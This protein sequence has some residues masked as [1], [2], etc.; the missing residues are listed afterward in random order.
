MYF[1]LSDS[2]IPLKPGDVVETANGSRIIID[3]YQG[4]G[5]FALMYIAHRE[6]S[7]R[8]LA[9]K[10]LFPRQLENLLIQRGEDGR[11][12]ICDPAADAEQDHTPLWRELQKYFVREAALTRK[13]GTAYDQTGHRTAQ[14]NPDVLHAEGPFQ[15]LRGNTY[16]A[17]DTYQGEPLRDLIERG[18]LRDES[19]AVL[20]NHFL[21]EILDILTEAAVRLSALHSEGIWH[22]DLSPDNIYLVPSVGRT[23]LAP[24]IIDYGSSYDRNDPKD[25]AD[26][27]YTYNPFS[28][29]EILALAQLQGHGGGYAPDAS[30]DTYAL[31]AILFY[32]VTGE[33]FTAEHRMNRSRWQ[34]QIRREYAAGL[35]AH[36][37]ADSFA[38]AMIA[39]FDQ[40]LAAAQ[41]DRLPTPDALHEAIKNLR[42]QYEKYGNLLPLVPQDELMSYM[43]LEKYPLYQYRS[44]DGS[45][46][47]L[48]LG[49]GVFV[50]RMILSLISCGQMAKS[51]LYIHVVSAEPEEALRRHLETAAPLLARYSNLD[52]PVEH[53]YVTFSYHQVDDLL[54][55]SV[56]QEVLA[57]HSDCRY[58][59]VSLGS[60]RANI[61]AARLYALRLAELPAARRTVINYYCSE[62]AANNIHALLD[63]Q[64]LPDWL[65][66]DAFGSNLSAY[67]KTIRTLGL[68]TLKVAHLYNKLGDPRISLAESAQKLTADEYSQRSS[69]ATALHLKYKLAS[70]GINMTPTT[71]HRAIISAYQKVLAG[72]GFGEQMELEHRRWMMYMIADGYQVP[73]PHQLDR[74]GF[75]MLDEKT[76]NANWKCTREGLHPCLVPCGTDG[77]TLT[78]DSWEE[79]STEE[80]IDNAP[81]DPLDKVSLRLHARSKKKC[82]RILE[83]RI[84]ENHFLSIEQKLTYAQRDAENDPERKAAAIPFDTMRTT[85]NKLRDSICRD[86]ANLAYT[87]DQGQLAALLRLFETW[88]INIKESVTALQRTLSVFVECAK[89][90][91]YKEPDETIIRH[92]LWL[93]YAEND[94]TCIK[95]RGRA[96]ADNI[97]GPLILEPHRLVFFGQERREEWDEFLRSHGNRGEIAYLPHCGSTLEQIATCL[98]RTAAQ[99]R[100]GCIIDITGADEQMVIAAQRV[101]DSNSKVSLI[102]CTP[103]GRVENVQRFPTA[104]AYTLNTTIAADEIFTLHG[105]KKLPNGGRYMEQ[106][107]ELIPD[108]WELFTNFRND[109]NEITAFFAS[110]GYATPE[111]HI[112]NIRIDETSVWK[113]HTHVVDQ[114]KWKS[115]ELAAVFRKMRDMGIIRQLETEPYRNNRLKVSYLYAANNSFFPTALEVLLKEKLPTIFDPLHCHISRSSSAFIVDITTGCSVKINDDKNLDFEDKRYQSNQPPRFAYAR[116]LPAL[117]WMAKKELITDLK[118]S[119]DLTALPVSISFLYAKPA[120]R[121]CLGTA[122]NIL[123]LKIWKEARKTHA[124]DHVLPNLS[125]TWREGIDN[126]LDVILTK[127]L[128]SLI[129]SAKTARFNREHLYEIKYLTEH[130]SL[131]SKPVIVYAS[132]KPHFRDSRGDDMLAVKSRARAMGVYLLDLNELIEQ[133]ESLG[134]RLAAIAGGT[135]SL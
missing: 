117:K 97:T 130:F 10:E 6:G 129:V 2:R 128:T 86:A 56:C 1:Q 36:Q 70:A 34:E 52:K 20:S 104:P 85:L 59:L 116:V 64:T 17:I 38:G 67:S 62:D 15:D 92:L 87:G 113:Q 35:P 94:I 41:A 24:F 115:L 65:E 126:E 106:V 22:L 125:F 96:I 120:L 54:R 37:G 133:K 49:S 55:E 77:V 79:Y 135:A 29:P 99:Q 127:G 74:Y 95:L 72:K 91:D 18:F 50:R 101:A 9:L 60:N 68:R 3:R 26:H 90:R 107:E 112:Y 46:H 75:E 110:R 93:L 47:V 132:N 108:L 42:S 69:C 118:V 43:V 80:K 103:D 57:R 88:D 73:K 89:R 27:R 21:P 122:G 53:E 98:K 40:A 13:A 66:V 78:N 82:L 102:R 123:E 83:Q 4:S 16:L 12:V 111:A 84:I 28:A 14:N 8:F 11:I 31:A 114:A 109:W 33:I 134:D 39:F 19:G 131:N 44:G 5:G 30:S 119:G 23:R 105:A 48:C 61:D 45:I 76:F 7:S 51:R 25:T 124:F 81:F 32:A 100:T 58:V 71:T 63:R 121:N